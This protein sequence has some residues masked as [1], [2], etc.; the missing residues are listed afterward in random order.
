MTI[1]EA[2]NIL[3]N[4]ADGLTD[5]EVQEIVDWLNMM[6]DVTIEAVEKNTLKIVKN[7]F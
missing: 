5:N 3:E 4:D 1:K 6:A 7:N 2:R